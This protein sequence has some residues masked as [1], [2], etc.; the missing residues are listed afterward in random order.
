MCDFQ[1]AFKRTVGFEGIYSNDPDDHGGE[2]YKGVSRHYWPEWPGWPIVDAHKDADNFPSCLAAD[3]VLIQHVQLFYR[4]KFWL[5]MACDRIPHQPLANELFDTGVNIGLYPTIR[6]LQIGL[7][8]INK[9]GTLWPDIKEDGIAGPVTIAALDAAME[10]LAVSHGEYCACP[11]CILT[12]AVNCQQG[13]YYLLQSKEKF[14]PGLF[15][16]RI[17]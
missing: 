13:V 6:F 7:N 4:D 1:T 3:P 5:P 14:I 11:G 16:K 15:A 12:K 8:R 2:T 10:H 17:T 9:L